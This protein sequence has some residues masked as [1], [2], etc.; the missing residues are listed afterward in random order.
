MLKIIFENKKLRQAAL[1]CLILSGI[2]WY[3]YYAFT[4]K[5]FPDY[6]YVKRVVDGDTFV[7]SDNKRY[8]F[9][10]IDTPELAR[11]NKPEEPYAR[12]ATE[13][14]KQLIE[15]K[16]IKIEFDEDKF[17]RYNRYLVYVYT[18]DGKMLNKLLLQEGLA[19]VYRK[20]PFELREEFFEIEKKAR[21]KGA[22]IWATKALKP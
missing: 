4:H 22:G 9:I 20:Q 12:Q 16:R 17:D 19:D 21:Q 8:R 18:P 10:G 1:Y 14:T 13:Y 2:I 6:V 7:D 11:N 5:P 15:N 3:V